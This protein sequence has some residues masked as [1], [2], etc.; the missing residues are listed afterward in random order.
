MT[1][2]MRERKIPLAT[3]AAC[4][5]VL[6]YFDDFLATDMIRHPRVLVCRLGRE[7]QQIVPVGLR[8]AQHQPTFYLA[9]PT[10]LYIKPKMHHIAVL[11]D[12]SFSFYPQATGV[13][14][15]IFAV[16]FN[17][18]IIADDFGA[19]KTFFKIGMNFAG[20]LWRGGVFLYRPG[21]DFFLAG[22]KKG[23]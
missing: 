6:V 9:Q 10:A 4:H 13:F 1:P 14:G 12:I 2:K 8:F 3:E 16:I 18:I 15:A 19:D 22:G 21:A 5:L 11:G 23:D 7:A 17:V 20:G